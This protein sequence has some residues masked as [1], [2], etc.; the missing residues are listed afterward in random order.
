[1]GRQDKDVIL[2]RGNIHVHVMKEV[3]E[4]AQRK[5]VADLHKE[6]HFFETARVDPEG[7]L[8]FPDAH[9]SKRLKAAPRWTP[10]TKPAP[11]PVRT[12][13]RTG[14]IEAPQGL[15]GDDAARLIAEFRAK[16]GV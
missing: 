1:V 9:K 13:Y 10:S 11:G 14:P 12:L 3:V 2:S 15:T 16:K 8:P 5:V 7:Y 6:N 4:K